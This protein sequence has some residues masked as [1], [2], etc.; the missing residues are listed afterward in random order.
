MVDL[1]LAETILRSNQDEKFDEAYSY[2]VDYPDEKLSFNNDRFYFANLGA[3]LCNK[4][5]REKKAKEFAIKALE[6]SNITKPDF[7][8]HPTL[9]LVKASQEQTEILQKIANT[10]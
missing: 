9:G 7:Y 1:K 8:R 10:V 5:K 3:L 4:M 2:V 6:L